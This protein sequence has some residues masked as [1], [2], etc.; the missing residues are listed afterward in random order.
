MAH[1]ACVCVCVS[2]RGD[3]HEGNAPMRKL[4]KCYSMRQPIEWW[5]AI[6]ISEN[7]F[8]EFTKENQHQFQQTYIFIQNI[9]MRAYAYIMHGNEFELSRTTYAR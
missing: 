8:N 2:R 1:N 4:Y 6:P 9:P 7:E 3:E 5:L